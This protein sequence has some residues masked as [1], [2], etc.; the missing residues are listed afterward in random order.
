[1][2]GTDAIRDTRS[3]VKMAAVA[4]VANCLASRWH[5]HE[6][7]AQFATFAGDPIAVPLG[8]ES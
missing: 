3:M 6:G 2:H 7:P 8:M 5:H 1:V 4:D